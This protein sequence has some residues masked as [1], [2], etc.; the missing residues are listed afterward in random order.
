MELYHSESLKL[1]N[2]IDLLKLF[3]GMRRKVVNSMF[4]AHTIAKVAKSETRK[5]K[6]TRKLEAQEAASRNERRKA[7]A[8]KK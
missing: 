3:N 2:M 1:Q 7:R 6:K 5:T 4:T 8:G